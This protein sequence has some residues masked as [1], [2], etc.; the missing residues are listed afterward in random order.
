VLGLSCVTNLAAGLG[1]TPL[2]HQ[3][4]IET[5]RQVVQRLARL[6]ERLAPGIAALPKRRN[7]DNESRRL[8][9]AAVCGASRM[10]GFRFLLA[11]L[12]GLPNFHSRLMQSTL[13][14]I[15]WKCEDEGHGIVRRRVAAWMRQGISR[16]GWR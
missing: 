7:R 11:A 1:A 12:V 8:V 5:G 3:E 13:I 4:V 2:S 10:E 9:S 6:L 15:P 14:P 16:G